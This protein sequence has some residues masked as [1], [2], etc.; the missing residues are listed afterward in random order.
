M[1]RCIAVLWRRSITF[2]RCNN[3]WW[4]IALHRG[5]Y[6]WWWWSIILRRGVGG[7]WGWFRWWRMS[8]LRL[9][10]HVIVYWWRIGWVSWLFGRMLD[11]R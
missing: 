8:W 2:D 7:S 4:T 5:N 11:Y 6:W 1:G 3:R 10:G 9:W